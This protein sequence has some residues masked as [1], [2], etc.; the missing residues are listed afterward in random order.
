MNEKPK[1]HPA[2]AALIVIALLGIVASVIVIVN[3]VNDTNTNDTSMASTT[4]TS[5]QPTNDSTDT[6]AYEDGTYSATGSYMSPG[7]RESIDLTV[8]IV[9]GVITDTSVQT[10]AA[11]RDSGQYQS[12]FSNN[13]KPLVVGKEVAGLSLSRVAGSSLTSNGFNDALDEI[14]D[15]ARI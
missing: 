15:E 4:M 2:L 6:S 3:T 12:L 5:E 1:L 7:G 11:D 14:R 9:D 8:T 10:H 13:Y